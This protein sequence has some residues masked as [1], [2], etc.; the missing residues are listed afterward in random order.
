MSQYN[1]FL[2]LEFRA[3]ISPNEIAFS[4]GVESLTFLSL[5]QLCLRVS[6]QLS[7]QNIAVGDRVILALTPKLGFIFTLALFHR[8]CLSCSSHLNT[9]LPDTLEFD[10]LITDR[11]AV[12]S[13]QPSVINIDQAWF[14][15]LPELSLRE[16][17]T[18]HDYGSSFCRMILTSGT[19]GVSKIVCLTPMQLNQRLNRNHM[20]WS[21]ASGNEINLMGLATIGGFMTMLYCMQVGRAV[22][23]P[24]SNETFLRMLREFYVVSLI[25]SPLQIN[26]ILDYK[27]SKQA[28]F[29]GI[30]EIRLAGS[31]ISGVLVKR[32]HNLFSGKLYGVYGSTEVGG[33]G[34]IELAQPSDVTNAAYV[35]PGVEVQIVDELD[36]SVDFGVEGN[37][38]IK[39][40]GMIHDYE[41]DAEASRQSFRDGWF[42][43]GDR[44]KLQP[45]GLLSLTG[46]T[47][48][49]INLG[50]WKINPDELDNVAETYTG[51]KDAA[52]FAIDLPNG[53][54]GIAMAI[55][56]NT[57]IN[58]DVFRDFLLE[59]LDP[60]STPTYFFRV[61]SIP[62][63]GMGKK[64][65]SRLNEELR[66]LIA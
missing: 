60:K 59:S 57:N 15:N 12:L 62:R 16:N 50:G 27:Q 17:S 25:A 10:W 34:M 42:Y 6:K 63:N 19:T 65:R 4:D 40:A 24:T 11:D 9:K 35:Q 5:H 53:T 23:L 66:N 43:P 14:S 38:R 45:Q 18:P 41:D 21:C 61:N 52:S 49:I 39:S 33:V 22:L 37:I 55:V 51:L 56:E 32:V 29:A 54:V 30:R 58:L 47:A 7:L 26:N 3:K 20:I 64:L 31:S 46:R 13:E 28:L 2:L 48:E 1:P 36:N 8:G 44:G